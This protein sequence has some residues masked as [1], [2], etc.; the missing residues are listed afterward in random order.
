MPAFRA[1]SRRDLMSAEPFSAGITSSRTKAA[2][3]SRN[4]TRSFGSSKSIASALQI[5]ENGRGSLTAAHAHC[6]HPVARAATAH[7]A[8]ELHGELGAGSAEGMAERNRAA[9]HVDALLVHPQL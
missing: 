4:S 9:V 2:T 5:L 6:H 3:R 1:L 8:E 7:L